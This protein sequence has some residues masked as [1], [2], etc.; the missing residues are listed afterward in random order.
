MTMWRLELLVISKWSAMKTQFSTSVFVMV[1][2]G[3][4][5]VIHLHNTNYTFKLTSVCEYWEKD[6]VA[7]V[8]LCYVRY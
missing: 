4:T 2:G 3:A 7:I 5:L 8:L 1:G 6:K